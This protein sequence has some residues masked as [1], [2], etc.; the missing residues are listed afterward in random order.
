[1]ERPIPESP[2]CED[3]A[4]QGSEAENEKTTVLRLDRL[5][6]DPLG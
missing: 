6:V 1:M 2:L 4:D 3:F 5:S